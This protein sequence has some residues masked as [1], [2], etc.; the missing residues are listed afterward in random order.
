MPT[1][2]V[3]M[4]ATAKGL[5]NPK[6]LSNDVQA[7]SEAVEKFGGKQIDWNLTMGPLRRRS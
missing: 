6:T 3:L 4:K 5:A 2:I 7:A 1:Y